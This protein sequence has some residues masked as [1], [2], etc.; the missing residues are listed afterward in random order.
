MEPI[1]GLND[2]RLFTSTRFGSLKRFTYEHI[3]DEVNKSRDG[4][5]RRG[6]SQGYTIFIREILTIIEAY[7]Q[8]WD[9]P[10]KT[11]KPALDLAQC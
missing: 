11:K 5:V 3:F 8:G 1:I 10:N 9:L 4:K 2:N 7:T 6:H